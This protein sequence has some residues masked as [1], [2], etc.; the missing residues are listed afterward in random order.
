[1]HMHMFTC[2]TINLLYA[3]LYHHGHLLLNEQDARRLKN[4]ELRAP[5]SDFYL[6]RIIL[7]FVKLTLVK[8]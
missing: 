6:I 4:K 3:L 8:A 2:S 7:L 5:Y 1:M